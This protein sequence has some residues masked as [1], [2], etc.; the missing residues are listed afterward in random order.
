MRLKSLLAALFLLAA[1]PAN[2]GELLR[3][4]HFTALDGW[5]ATSNLKM[6]GGHGKLC[7]DVP[8]GTANP[9]DAIVGQDGL[10][11][12][13][14]SFYRLSLT[15]SGTP[16][17]PVSAQLQLPQPPYTALVQDTTPAGAKAERR[18]EFTARSDVPKAQLSIQLGGNPTPWRFCLHQ[19]S[20]RDDLPPPAGP[21]A[22]GPRLKVNQLGYLPGGPKRATLVSTADAP[23]DFTLRDASGA[24]VFTGAGQP[25][26]IDHASGLNVQVLDF[27]SFPGTGKDFTLAAD[28]DTSYPFA[29][30][31]GLYAPLRHDAFSFFYPMRSGIAIDGTIA[32]ADYARDAGHLGR[33][34]GEGPNQ[35]DFAVPCKPA[36][37]LP[38]EPDWDCTYVQDATGGWYDA[39]DQ[40][41]YVVNGA[42]SA[43]QLLFAYETD[44]AAGGSGLGDRSLAIPE[45]GN[46][47]SDALDE[48]R[49]E[50]DWML[51]MIVPAGQPLAGMLHHK[52]SDDQ[53]TG[54]PTLPADDP[55][56]RE[57]H[58]PTTAATL[59]FAAVAAMASRLYAPGDTVYAATLLAAARTAY[60]AAR[61]NPD[62]YATGGGYD[63]RDARDEF[64]WAAA[65]LYLTTGDATYRADLEA[66]PGWNAELYVQDG[67]SWQQV[68]PFA[69]LELARHADRLDAA[70]T[71][72]WRAA[73]QAGADK[74]LALQQAEPFGLA[75]TPSDGTYAWGSNAQ[76]LANAQVLATA[77]DILGTPA[78]RA[79]AIESM[80]Y[81]LGR[82]GIGQS[83]VTGYGTKFSQNQH[84]RWFAHARDS[85]LP[86][87]P[88]GALAGGANSALQDPVMQSRF[89]AMPCAPQLCYVDDIDAY[90]VNEIAINWNAGLA[91]M[92][93][94][95]ALQ[96]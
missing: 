76:I 5:W 21:A 72:H 58:P 11:I 59:D 37:P 64:F 57:L 86:H 81:I 38:E 52:L 24:T 33:P 73:L 39:G 27:T 62:R 48:V 34:G 50:L 36:Q 88:H 74:L 69:A 7:V 31:D 30:A 12:A 9:W 94:W 66:S 6:T 92:A 65:E 49:W 43:A 23:V 35:G 78:Y 83:Y 20:L 40:G 71:A 1:V 45:A 22:T 46:G 18:L 56:P 14:G 84:S 13:A 16:E 10:R 3:N 42:V 55:R 2:A 68:A 75:Y 95:L 60:D 29:I 77:A 44:L 61:R 82:N 17:G 25:L 15:L 26:G 28:G 54:I 51:K 93:T 87:P 80:D 47:V 53:W 96:R 32:G 79:A 89:G 91:A 90:S 63:D 85:R 8:G 4:G 70:A 41:K 19:A 67:F